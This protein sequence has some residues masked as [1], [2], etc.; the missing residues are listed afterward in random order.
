MLVPPFGV[1][2]LV[3]F[4]PTPYAL[5]ESKLVRWFLVQKQ[6]H[7]GAGAPSDHFGGGGGMN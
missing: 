5:A 6:T 7:I 3:R 4:E 1:V 2:F